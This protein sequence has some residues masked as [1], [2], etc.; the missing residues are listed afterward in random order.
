[1]FCF[2][3]ALMVLFTGRDRRGPEPMPA[4]LPAE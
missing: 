1:M 2:A 3:A 4:V